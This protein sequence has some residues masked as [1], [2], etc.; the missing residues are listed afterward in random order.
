MQITR[1]LATLRRLEDE[2]CLLCV[3]QCFKG[4]RDEA[5]AAIELALRFGIVAGL[6]TA[7][8]LGKQIAERPGAELQSGALQGMRRTRGARRVAAG[9]A[10][11]ECRGEP[12]ESVFQRPHETG[13]DVIAAELALDVP[14][15]ID[16]QAVEQRAV[17]VRCRKGAH[18]DIVAIASSAPRRRSKHHTFAGRISRRLKDFLTRRVARFLPGDTGRNG[19]RVL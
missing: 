2:P 15:F 6:G 3:L 10:I 5:G 19:I 18:A 17:C 7:L 1:R 13:K 12:R 4:L 11:A 16:G 8:D 14:D 9:N